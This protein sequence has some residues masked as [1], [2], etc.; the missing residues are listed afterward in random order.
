MQRFARLTL[1]IAI[2]CTTASTALAD[3]PLRV[4]IFAAGHADAT[5][6]RVPSGEVILFDAGRGDA[7]WLGDNLVKRRLLPFFRAQG[8]KRIDA[9]FISHAHW[10]HFGDIAAL[11]AGV[12]IGHIYVNRDS[13]HHLGSELAATGV[14]R[15]ILARGK[16]VRFGKL[17]IDILGPPPSRRPRRMS[18]GPINNNSLVLRLRYGRTRFLLPGDVMRGGERRLLR[19]GRLGRVD[20]LKLGHHGLHTPVKG[21]LA[22]LR[23]KFAVA[24][25]GDKWRQRVDY[26]PRGLLSALR[27]R[28]VTLLRT[29][30]DGDIVFASD[31]RQVTVRRERAHRYVPAW[32][33]A[34]RRARASRSRPRRAKVRRQ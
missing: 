1:A 17:T 14:P 31:G 12:R 15:T 29:D 33:A 7:S 30:R 27:R 18:I 11:A 5:L 8:I 32:L 20:V 16:T 19:E 2:A 10:D 4:R 24:S 23:P 28:R 3:E 13:D 21:W 25:C 9:F 34:R 22:R 26:V 6:I